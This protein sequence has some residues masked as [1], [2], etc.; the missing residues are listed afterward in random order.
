[1]TRLAVLLL[2]LFTFFPNS[3]SVAG[4]ETV[5]ITAA[6][7]SIDFTTGTPEVTFGGVPATSVAVVDSKHLNVQTPPHAEGAVRVTLHINGT[8]STS[9]SY[10]GFLRARETLLIPVAT[11]TGG[12]FG[13]RW[14]TDIWVYND[15]G[16]AV[17][18]TPDICFSLG[19]FFPCTSALVVEP[20]AALKIAP[21]GHP[22]MYLTPP[23]DVRDKLH[24]GVR[25]RD[26]SRDEA[27]TEIPIVPLSSYRSARVVLV[28]V[29]VSDR[30]RS[31]LRV[32]DSP[33]LVGSAVT[34]RI[35]DTTT[36]SLLTTRMS[37][38]NFAPTDNPILFTA[39]F[40]DLLDDP[41]VRGHASVRIEIEDLDASLWAMLTLTDNT[42][43]HV[44]VLTSQ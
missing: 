8:T 40:F 28:N 3:G 44:T 29:P 12:A 13:A 23:N 26:A 32:Y 10:F 22:E 17:S 31:V 5:Q 1:M 34:V 14:T 43:Q 11:E 38:R 27:E 36:G 2:Q 21:V 30:M 42:T 18:L 9:D 15:A 25:V 37:D 19:S 35:F 7:A 33:R 6:D 16:E 39:T 20:H 41:A 24:F 4:G